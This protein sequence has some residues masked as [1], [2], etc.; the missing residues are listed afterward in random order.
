MVLSTA[1]RA[2]LSRLRTAPPILKGLLDG[3]G[4]HIGMPMM[5]IEFLRI[6]LRYFQLYLGST[7]FAAAW[8]GHLVGGAIL[9]GSAAAVWCAVFEHRRRA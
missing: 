1:A 9:M 4:V 6:Y 5:T 3:F 2:T 8:L 7:G